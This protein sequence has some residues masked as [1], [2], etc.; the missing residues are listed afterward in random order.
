MP[1]R[2]ACDVCYRRKIQC[3]IKTRGDPC[4]WCSSQGIECTFDRVIQK[5][6]NKRTT[7][8][9]VQEL[10]HRVEELEEALRSALSPNHTPTAAAA[11]PWS[12]RSLVEAPTH[13]PA[14][15]AT[16]PAA[17]PATRQ[18][19][20]ENRANPI[21]G[22]T[23][24]SGRAYKLS[25]CHLGSNW[26][27]KGVGLFSTRGR[28]WISEGTGETTFLENFGIFG[29]PLGSKP[30]SRCLAP[31]VTLD[32]ARSLPPEPTCRYLFSVFLRSKTAIV[33]PILD[34][35]LFE[36]TIAEAYK[37]D[38]PDR[39]SRASAEACLWGMLALVGR[40][41]EA[42]GVNSLADAHSCV[43]EVKRLLILVDGAVNLDTLQATLL[44][45]AYQKMKGKCRDASTTFTSACRMVCDLGGHILLPELAIQPQHIPIFDDRVRLHIRSL[46]WLCYCFDKDVS[47]R[48]GCPPLLTSAHCDL[49]GRAGE[50][51]GYSN[52]TDTTAWYNQSRNTE[53]AKIKETASRLLC[54]PHAFKRTEGELLAHVRQLDDEL[55]EWRLSIDPS[56]RPRLSIPSDY[57]LSTLPQT[58]TTTGTT[59]INPE[60]RTTRIINLQLD[61]LFTVINIHTLVRKC[62]DLARNLPDDLHSVV[63]SSADLSIEAS[64]SIF[65]FLATTVVDFWGADAIWV[66]AH[67]AP[68]AAMPL[69]L[70]III[71][72]VGNPADSDLQILASIGDITRAIPTEG[73]GSDEIEHVQEI[74]EFVMELIRLSHSA[75]WKAKKGERVRD[76]DIIHR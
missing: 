54:S 64:R 55:E 8:D 56:C 52:Q 70:N 46:F 33:F 73:L 31:T 68:M 16:T 13:T 42:K 48:T 21:P 60:A 57:S 58:T 76:L 9:V 15:F 39:S 62:G 28:Q 53:L 69:F 75:A 24:Q 36:E 44:L 41:Q 1:P 34:R 10:S 35:R 67:Y 25:R 11:S 26:Y 74:G 37:V 63:H 12:E 30:C 51:P 27:F 20:T 43:Q 5:D 59:S 47:I 66:V 18:Q 65:R 38:A 32:R 23:A 22:E 40:T 49:S 6:P 17:A 2:R 3:S 19:R 7:S 29:N 45:W 4:D 61:Y 50:L 72:P 71:H 14:Y